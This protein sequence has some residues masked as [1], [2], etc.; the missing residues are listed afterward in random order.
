MKEIA[1]SEVENPEAPGDGWFIIE[2]AGRH[3]TRRGE[4]EFTQNLSP[5][6]LAGIVEAGVPAEGLPIDRDHLSLDERN[7]TEALGWVRE[8]A[9]CD[10]DLAGRIEWTPLGLPL[11]QGRVY[12]H[13]SSV[14]PPPGEQLAGGEYMPERLIGLALTNQPNNKEGQPPITNSRERVGEV[15][16]TR[17]RSCG[18]TP[19]QAN[20]PSSPIGYAEAGEVRMENSAPAAQEWEE[21]EA[22]YLWPREDFSEGEVPEEA[23]NNKNEEPTM[24]SPELLSA[25]GLTEGATEADVLAAVQKLKQSAEVA[26]AAVKKAEAAEAEAVINAAERENGVELSE[27]EKEEAKQHIITNRAHGLKYVGLLCRDKRPAA[28]AA[29]EQPVAN[30]RRYAG[31]MP[32]VNRSVPEDGEKAIANRAQQLCDEARAAGKHLGYFTAVEMARTEAARN[33]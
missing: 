19:R 16:G 6:V 14:Y 28:A 31:K 3:A 7:S 21:D 33:K 8:L 30:T 26:N 13:F 23:E 9:M 17:L 5:E 2:A 18:A 11:I 27:E 1:K 15:R 22:G 20:D 12:K 25:L 10:G 32:L 4:V 24:Y 29:A